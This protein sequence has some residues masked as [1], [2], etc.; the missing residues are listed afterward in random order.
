MEPERKI[1][2]DETPEAVDGRLPMG[3]Q[4]QPSFR[5]QITYR[6]RDGTERRVENAF[7]LTPR[8][9]APSLTDALTAPIYTVQDG[10]DLAKQ[11]FQQHLAIHGA[12]WTSLTVTGP[13]Q[14]ITHRETNPDAE[15]ERAEAQGGAMDGPSAGKYQGDELEHYQMAYHGALRR[16]VVEVEAD[17]KDLVAWVE[18]Q[19]Q[20]G[21]VV[22]GWKL[23]RLQGYADA[24][25]SL[26]GGDAASAGD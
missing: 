25:A 15:K 12:V 17:R 11:Q 5:V 18:A 4:R 21:A 7:W 23:A 9:A 8:D 10:V 3:R 1:S 26:F 6:D 14:A 13:D 16:S 22:P 20:V 2:R 24:L 19:R